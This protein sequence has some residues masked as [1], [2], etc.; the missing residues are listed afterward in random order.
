MYAHYRMTIEIMGDA[1]PTRID[2]APLSNG[3]AARKVDVS[4][5][6]RVWASCA[7]RPPAE[8]CSGG[9]RL[10]PLAADDEPS[11]RM[12]ISAISLVCL[13][14]LHLL[15]VFKKIWFIKYLH[16]IS[17]PSFI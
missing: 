6:R 8:G 3:T 1:H 2:N 16:L 5:K 11:R 10:P 12:G 9:G 17:H 13:R 7:E 15:Y 14:V 4:S